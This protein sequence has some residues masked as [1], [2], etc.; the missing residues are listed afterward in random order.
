[1]DLAVGSLTEPPNPITKPRGQGLERFFNSPLFS[2]LTVCF[3]GREVH[4]HK[5]IICSQSKWFAVAF[6]GCFSEAAKPTIELEDD[7]ANSV[8]SMLRFFY[9]LNPIEKREDSSPGDV[10]SEV[11]RIYLTA[12]KYDVPL[13]QSTMLDTFKTLAMSSC[14]ELLTS[15]VLSG[16]I[17]SIYH[18]TASG[19]PLRKMIQE[20]CL[21]NF[22]TFRENNPV[23]FRTMFEENPE[24]SADVLMVI[25]EL[26]SPGSKAIKNSNIEG[27]KTELHWAAQR[28]E[29]AK[30]RRLLDEGIPVDVNDEDGETP[31]HFATWYGQFEVTQL[32][33]ER[34]AEVNAR[35]HRYRRTPLVWA[36]S[37][38]HQNITEFLR[39]HG[40]TL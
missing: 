30:C 23:G 20:V 38:N 12:D 21:L 2:D 8:E 3:S 35:G 33:V 39:S 19:D 5:V 36:E 6:G 37:R 9:G 27:T 14:V 29:L 10:L 13:L 17:D 24:F 31:L 34:G 26:K 15:G 25:P 32:L 18:S 40:G 4:V 1:M 22:S 28:G 11:V 16:I 7:E